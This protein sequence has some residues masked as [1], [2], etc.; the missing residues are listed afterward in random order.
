MDIFSIANLWELSK[1]VTR[2]LGQQRPTW[3]CR[4]TQCNPI[5]VGFG[6]GVQC[7]IWARVD[8]PLKV[9]VSV[10]NGTYHV[11]GSLFDPQVFEKGAR[12][13]IDLSLEAT[14]P[15]VTGSATPPLR[16]RLLL[17]KV[18]QLASQMQDAADVRWTQ[19]LLDHSLQRVPHLSD[20]AARIAWTWFLVL[21]RNE[22]AP[23][24]FP[25]LARRCQPL[26]EATIQANRAQQPLLLDPLPAYER[27]L[28]D[29]TH[30]EQSETSHSYSWFLGKATLET[31]LVAGGLL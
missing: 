16:R 14:L 15:F 12:L 27:H 2:I 3:T 5:L 6:T 29:P 24:A 28:H 17:E 20:Q 13:I 7:R 30:V 1:A 4:P 8:A 31:M 21:L 10:N 18:V 22:L 11:V 19:E 25:D 26:R 9:V 23:Q